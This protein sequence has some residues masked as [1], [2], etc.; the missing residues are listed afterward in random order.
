M[1][2]RCCD[3]DDGCCM[4]EVEPKPDIPPKWCPWQ[5]AILVKWEEY[6]EIEP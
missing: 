3:C 1:K 5:D 6:E 4:L 2:Y